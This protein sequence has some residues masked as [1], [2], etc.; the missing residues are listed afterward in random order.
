MIGGELWRCVCVYERVRTLSDSRCNH[1]VRLQRIPL[2]NLL[3]LLFWVCK[4]NGIFNIL[5]VVNQPTKIVMVDTF[6]TY[7]VE[8]SCVDVG[9]QADSMWN[10]IILLQN[11]C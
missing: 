3:W 7:Y 9:G 10:I 11:N 5:G 1:T 2:E 8:I 6:V 4:L